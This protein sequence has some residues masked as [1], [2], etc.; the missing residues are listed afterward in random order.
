MKIQTL[1]LVAAAFMAMGSGAAHAQDVAAG[2]AVYAQCVACHSVDATNGAGPGLKG[3]VGRKAGSHPGFRY[4][5]A[6]KATAYS[7]DDKSLDAYIANPQMA[8]PGNQ[9]PYSGIAD[10]KQRADLIAYLNTLK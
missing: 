6:M 4:S 8:I 1:G 10:A 9:M 3:I 5:R 2:K 7:W